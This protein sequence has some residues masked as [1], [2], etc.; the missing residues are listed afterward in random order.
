MVDMMWLYNFCMIVYAALVRVAS[1][2]NKKAKLWCSGRKGMF[3]RMRSAMSEGER[4]V[5]IHVASLGDFEQGRPLVDYIKENYPDHKI[6][7]TFFSP[8]GYEVRKNYKNADYVFYI[9]ADTKRNVR[10]FLDI[11]N[12]EV[13][14]FV[15]YEFW[16]N[17]LAE[18]HKRNIRTYIA[19]AIFRRNSIFF[20]PFGFWWRKALRC[21]DTLFVQDDYSK[22]LLEG[23]GVTNVVVAGD[24]RFDRVATIAEGAERVAV[25]EEFKGNKRLF[26]AGSTWGAD[27]DILLPLINENPDIKFVIA[28]HEMDEVR[29]E[30]ILHETK[31]GAVRYTQL[32]EADLADKQVLVLDTMG[33]LSRV[34]G[35]AEWAYIGGG[36]GAGIH[37][38]LEAAVYGLPVAFGTKYRKFKEACDLIEL[39]VGRS[40]ADE[41][42]LKAWFD[43]LKNDDDYL[44]RLSALAKVYVGKHRGATEKI[45]K[46]IAL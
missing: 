23:I 39:G 9:P 32:A 27:E 12:P 28:P 8:S 45:V 19:S 14:I 17:M 22:Q 3:E 34:Y 40:V 2:F 6:L 13:V 35:S 24:T 16:L 10:Q 5:W 15:K 7:L 37:N 30:R 18:L 25:V 4:I 31:G 42:E 46:E 26:V 11:A 1:P 44:A 29:I 38:T 33:L 20:N 36:F 43:E 21:F 41:C